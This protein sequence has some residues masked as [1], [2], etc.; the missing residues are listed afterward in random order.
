MIDVTI[1]S[2]PSTSGNV[3]APGTVPR[4]RWPSSIAA[5]VVTTYVSNRSAAMPAQSPTLSPT[6]SAM[7]AG[8]RGSSSGMPA[9]TL[10]TRSAPT[11][12]A[13]VKM[14]PPR[15]ANTE[16]SE[17]PNAR[18]TSAAERTRF[19]AGVRREQDPVVAADREQAEADDEQP[20]H[21]AA[22]EREVQRRSETA[23]RRFRRAHVR[24]HRDDHADEAGGAR[25]DRADREAD[26]RFPAERRG[27]EADDD[28]EDDRDDG[29]RRVLTPQERHR[30]LLDRGRDR[31]HRG[32]S[33][34]LPEYP[35]DQV[36]TVQNR[37]DTGDQ[38]ELDPELRCQRQ[39]ASP[40]RDTKERLDGRRAPRTVRRLAQP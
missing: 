27:Q 35:R 20:G 33:G 17:Q 37:H 34:R 12:A 10:P 21:R 6:L 32:V 39:T 36:K 16:I 8:L 18:P 23:A 28:E 3:V 22:A 13:F 11:S 4:I 30:A 5:V 14:P 29:D 1:E 25:E 40:L 19:V 26:R 38:A 24:A 31:L 9:S 7:T 2:A 15:R